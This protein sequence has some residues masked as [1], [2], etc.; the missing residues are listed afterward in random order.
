MKGY[1]LGLDQPQKRR[2]LITLYQKLL[3]T[4]LIIL[5]FTLIYFLFRELFYIIKDAFLENNNVHD[6]L[7]KVLVFF[8]YFAFVSMIVKY[9]NESNHFPLDYLLYIGLTAG[10]RFIIVNNGNPLENFWLSLVIL[11]L[12]IS[13]V[14]VTPKMKR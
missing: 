4:S 7:G 3:N 1:I 10:V 13:Y 6:I 9:F 11:I 12:A 5:G 14:M 8:L 2:G